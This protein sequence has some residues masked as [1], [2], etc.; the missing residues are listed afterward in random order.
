MTNDKEKIIK[1]MQDVIYQTKLDDITE[2]PESEFEIFNCCA[3]AEDKP[4]AGS[5]MYSKYRLCN[6][7]VLMYETALKLNKIKDINDFMEHMEERRL[8]NMCE[9]IK[10][11]SLKEN[12]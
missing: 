9:F 10:Q 6:D 2:N 11:D 12:N 1:D 7:C 5:I 8:K 3:C 4:L